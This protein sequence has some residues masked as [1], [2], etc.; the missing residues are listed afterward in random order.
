MRNE[1]IR[2]ST[3]PPRIGYVK[4]ASAW[5]YAAALILSRGA[6]AAATVVPP[7]P[8]GVPPAPALPKPAITAEQR[9]TA[10]EL[11][12][13]QEETVLLKA[14]LRMLDARAEVAARTQALS[15]LD[16][17][18]NV[19]VGHGATPRVLSIEGLDKRFSATLQTA[20]GE[21]FDVKPGDTLPG[22]IHVESIGPNRVTVRI[23]G[24]QHQLMPSADDDPAQA[25]AAAAPTPAAAVPQTAPAVPLPTRFAPLR[26][27]Q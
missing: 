17:A 21:R 25:N 27:T 2:A 22:G 12:R 23:A 13:L 1:R 18:G 8:T 10:E 20:D 6:W 24:Y 15:Q 26:E 19:S 5:A 7:A 14:Q 3:R 11:T 16:D 9:N 4:L